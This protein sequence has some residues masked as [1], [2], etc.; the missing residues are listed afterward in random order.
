[1]ATA[2]AGDTARAWDLWQL[3]NPVLHAAD[4]E[5]AARYKVEPYV[6]AADLYS[7]PPHAGRGGWTWYTGSAGW[8]YRLLV[9]TFL[10]LTLEVDRLR[11]QP[12]VPAQWERFTVHYRFRETVYHIKLENTTGSWR[13]IPVIVLDGNKLADPWIP[14]VDDRNDHYAE[15]RLA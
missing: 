4:P 10:G 6:I 13:G 1:M 14:L 15:V 12:R 2:L 8:T 9:E 11:F 3:I 5:G 7:L